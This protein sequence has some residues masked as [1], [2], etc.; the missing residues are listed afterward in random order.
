MIR[1]QIQLTEE[2]AAALRA[3]TAIQHV[4]MAEL[5]RRSIDLFVRR[6]SASSR[7]A[8]VVRAKSA[9]GSFS[10]GASNVGV[11]HDQYLAEAFQHE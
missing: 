6:E 3:L 7:G 5:I 2:Q 9:I 11:D 1:T 10:S 4:S 8:A